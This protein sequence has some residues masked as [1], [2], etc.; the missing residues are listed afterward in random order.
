MGKAGCM[1]RSDDGH[2]DDDADLDHGEGDEDDDDDLDDGEDDHEDN[3]NVS[4]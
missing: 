1:D 3:E 4:G 2:G